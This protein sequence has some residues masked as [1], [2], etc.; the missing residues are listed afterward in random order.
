VTL[1]K[2]PT[3]V[4]MFPVMSYPDRVTMRW[5]RPYSTAPDIAVTIPI[6]VARLPHPSR[7]RSRAIMLNNWSRRSD[8]YINLCVRS[9]G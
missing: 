7:V 1:N 6:V 9:R 3:I 8:V 5:L 2:N 4:A